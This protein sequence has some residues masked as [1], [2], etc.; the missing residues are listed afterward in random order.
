M[1]VELAEHMTD[2]VVI[3]GVPTTM[4]GDPVAARIKEPFYSVQ[5]LDYSTEEARATD[6]HC[7]GWCFDVRLQEPSCFDDVHVS[8][9]IHWLVL[10]AGTWFSD[11]WQD[12]EH[13][14]H[15]MFQVGRLHVPDLFAAGSR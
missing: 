10:E 14:G 9:E 8:E 6:D 11:V 4:G 15:M 5:H 13:G 7:D 2:P 3:I 12:P 1:R